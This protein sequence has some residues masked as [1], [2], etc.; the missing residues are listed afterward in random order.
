MHSYRWP[1]SVAILVVTGLLMR[2]SPV[3]L[4]AIYPSDRQSET[5]WAVIA[6]VLIAIAGAGLLTRRLPWW[7]RGWGCG[8]LA[9]IVAMAWPHP[10]EGWSFLKFW[11][12]FWFGTLVIGFAG[13]F[14]FGSTLVAKPHDAHGQR[15]TPPVDALRS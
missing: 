13:G 6:T 4:S 15:V 11:W 3:A 5:P 14:A 10:V 8:L 12:L 7:V 1:V 9:V 2:W